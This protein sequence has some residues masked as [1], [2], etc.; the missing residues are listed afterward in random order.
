MKK[1]T[2]EAMLSEAM[3][4]VWHWK[5]RALAAEKEVRQLRKRSIPET[6]RFDIDNIVP[7]DNEWHHVRMDIDHKGKRTN[8][9]DGKRVEA[10]VKRSK[11]AESKETPA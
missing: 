6:I 4:W 1:V 9:L 2:L 10:H 7:T 3:G 5:D 11:P 8:W